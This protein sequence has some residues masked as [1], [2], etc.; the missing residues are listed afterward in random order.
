[1]KL[2]TTKEEIRMVKPPSVDELWSWYEMTGNMDADPSWAK[3]WET[4]MSFATA[5]AEASNTDVPNLKSKRLIAS[6]LTANCST[7]AML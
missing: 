5:I 1:M 6:W 4:A 2:G 3:N 7:R